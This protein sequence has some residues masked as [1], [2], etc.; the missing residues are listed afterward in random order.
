MQVG[1]S[2]EVNGGFDGLVGRSILAETDR[3]VRC[4]PDDLVATQSR[5]PNGPRGVG[6]EIL[7]QLLI[8]Q[9]VD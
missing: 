8:L 6:D 4:D 9:C 2:A 5:E 1:Q 7:C 3:V